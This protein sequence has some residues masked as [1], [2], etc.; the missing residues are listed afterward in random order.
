MNEGRFQCDLNINDKLERLFQNVFFELNS[1][2]NK[3]SEM[4]NSYKNNFKSARAVRSAS[5]LAPRE[6]ECT[7]TIP[8]LD[9][10]QVA[11]SGQ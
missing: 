3:M 6:G 2:L 7:Y 1:S 11:R 10:L 8:E 9:V 5:A 4:Y